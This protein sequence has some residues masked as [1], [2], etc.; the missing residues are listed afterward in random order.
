MTAE[1]NNSAVYSIQ[2]SHKCMRSDKWLNFN[3]QF[4]NKE[5]FVQIL[6]L[7]FNYAFLKNH[8]TEKS[9]LLVAIG[10]L[11]SVQYKFLS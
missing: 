5:S 3:M 6:K 1:H 9:A 2:F 4:K 7:T 11:L 10:F 8:F